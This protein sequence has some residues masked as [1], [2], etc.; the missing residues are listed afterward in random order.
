MQRISTE[1]ECPYPGR[2]SDYELIKKK[3]AE[4]IVVESNELRLRR[5]GLK[6]N[7]GPNVL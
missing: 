2:S 6:L 5:R 7:E 1:S 4:V 3:S